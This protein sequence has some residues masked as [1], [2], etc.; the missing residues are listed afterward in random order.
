MTS[1]EKIAFLGGQVHAL[2]G[3]ATALITSHPNLA[4]LA[5]HLEKAGELNLAR[6]ESM[7]V[8]DVYVE[9]VLD[10]KDRLREIVEIASGQRTRPSNG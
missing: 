3:F 7:P 5:E 6:A 10:V 4:L 2:I 9:G 8:A 1:E